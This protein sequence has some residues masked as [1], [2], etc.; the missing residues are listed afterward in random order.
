MK[1]DIEE[2]L[3]TESQINAIC[4]KLGTQITEDYKDKKPLLIG[5]L[6]GCI[7]FM[8][9]LA[10][11]IDLY[12]DIE[13][14]SVSSYHGGITSTGDVKITKDS[15]I[16]LKN[17]DVLII[18][19]IVDTANTITTMLEVFKNRGARSVK[20]VTLLDK[21]A[22]RLKPYVPDYIGTTIPNQFVV[23]YG[24]DYNELYRN[25]PYIGILKKAVYSNKES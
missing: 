7:P 20:V 25:L 8:S 2:I 3:V 14:L 23:G 13:Y 10:K 24:L 16:S 12:V 21:P 6:K 18:E 4:L 22:G 15:D 9:N 17:R 11:H 1:H 5:L 19:D